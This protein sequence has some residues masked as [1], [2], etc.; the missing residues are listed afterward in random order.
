MNLFKIYK[1]QVF[2]FLV[3]LLGSSCSSD[4]DFEQA[5]D[6]KLTPIF[7]T[8]LS[9]FSFLAKD[10]VTNGVETT[11]VYDS[12]TSD[13][14]DE[15]FFSKNLNRAD[16]FF[17][18]NNSTTRAFRMVIVLLDINDVPL[19][20]INFDIPASNGSAIRTV[21]QNK[22]YVGTRLDL[23]KR[24]VRIGF[25]LQLLPGAPLTEMST[26]KIELRS[27]ATSYFVVQ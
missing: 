21:T 10:I 13:I 25:A 8:N 19:D 3:A 26:G 11:V 22:V 7:E 18:V 16:L 15:E 9:Y 23:L 1:P 20:T 17:E 24:T 12:P 2:L 27:K 14:F 4:L 6:L 5:N